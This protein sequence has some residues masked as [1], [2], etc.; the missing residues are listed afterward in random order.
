MYKGVIPKD[1]RLE[2]RH[3]FIRNCRN[4]QGLR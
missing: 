2:V 1:K 4:L 3:L